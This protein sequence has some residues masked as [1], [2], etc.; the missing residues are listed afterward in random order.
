MSPG[1]DES[2]IWSRVA[3]R[4]S[5]DARKL[6]DLTRRELGIRFAFGALVSILSGLVG[7]AFG[8]RAGGIF[9]ASP[10]ILAASLTLI[11]K[12]ENSAEAREDARGATAGG[13][14]M[15]TFA[16]IAALSFGHLGWAVALLLASVS[17]LVVALGLY[18]LAWFR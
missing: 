5:I 3:E 7:L 17:W 12:Q 13:L 1:S 11:E 2:P 16:A 9:L 8:M 15:A 4:P 14:A 10:A 18:L 6:R